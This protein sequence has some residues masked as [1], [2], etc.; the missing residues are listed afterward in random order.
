[1]P[2]ERAT[3]LWRTRD[4][5]APGVGVNTDTNADTKADA[6]LGETR[7]IRRN[8]FHQFG[9]QISHFVTVL[10]VSDELS[11]NFGEEFFERDAFAYTHGNSLTPLCEVVL[12]GIGV[13]R[14]LLAQV[15]DLAAHVLNDLLACCV[16]LMEGIVLVTHGL[17]SCC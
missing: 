10:E 17:S 15:I 6:K 3:I 13:A 14:Q 2:R 5:D 12:K 11:G 4:V 1:M 7:R 9:H 8:L 16:K